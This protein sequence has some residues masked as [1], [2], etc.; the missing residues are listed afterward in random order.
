MPAQR[1]PEGVRRRPLLDA[2]EP[3]L[4]ELFA[5]TREQIVQAAGFDQDQREAFLRFQFDAQ[6]RHYAQFRP[7]GRFE[8]VLV[9][10]A[11]AGRLYV[12]ARPGTLYVID[13]SLLPRFRGRGIGTGLLCELI[14]QGACEGRSV[15]LHVD[16]GNR[17]RLLY[18][19]LGFEIVRED[20]A[21]LLMERRADARFVQAKTAS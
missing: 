9:D 5:S 14:D 18:E 20:G 17:A 21:D 7:Q 12:D 3:F 16:V 15:S 11:P 19:R 1:M 13:I 8:I 4:R 10:G 2:D 6:Q